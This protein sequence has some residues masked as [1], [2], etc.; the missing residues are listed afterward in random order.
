MAATARLLARGECDRRA[1]IRDVAALS[2]ED[3]R[4]RRLNRRP[5]YTADR[6]SDAGPTEVDDTTAVAAA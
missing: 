3:M 5:R 2:A 6:P 1:L 4:R